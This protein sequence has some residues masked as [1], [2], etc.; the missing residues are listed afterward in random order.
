MRTPSKVCF[1]SECIIG[2]RNDLYLI[3]YKEN[4]QWM[5]LSDDCDMVK[6][7]KTKY[8]EEKEEIN[9]ELPIISN[10]MMKKWCRSDWEYCVEDEVF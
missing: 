1:N 3:K 5:F 2:H 10:E 6:E 8:D 7:Y 4:V 9:D